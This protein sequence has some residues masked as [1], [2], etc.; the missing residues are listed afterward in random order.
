MHIQ[1]INFQ[2]DGMTEAEDSDLC[3]SLAPTF[4]TL[5]G[6]I[7]KVWLRDAE[8]NTY[9]GVYTW[10]SRE[11]ME[12]YLNSELFNAVATHP[13][14]VNASSRTFDVIEAPTRVTHGLVAV[15]A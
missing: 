4:A 1:I 15:T 10:E 14:V 5:P 13:N 6:L 12:R 11:A 3:D 8:S 9:G 7:S 2:L